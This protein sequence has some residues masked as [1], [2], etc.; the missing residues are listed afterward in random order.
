MTFGSSIGTLRNKTALLATTKHVHLPT[1]QEK[2]V[3]FPV[4]KNPAA[5]DAL[6]GLNE[7]TDYGLKSPLGWWHH[8]F[9][10]KFYPSLRRCVELKDK[11]VNERLDAAWLKFTKGSSKEVKSA[12]DLIVEREI[13][14]AQKEDRASDY[15]SKI[16]QDELTAFLMAGNDTTSATLE[17][18]IKY[19][20]A[21]QEWQT[22]LRSTLREQFD[23]KQ[24]SGL[25]IAKINTPELDA[26]VEE[27]L[28]VGSTAAFLFRRTK[29]DT[30]ILGHHV[31]AKT[32]LIMLVS[33]K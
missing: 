4:A 24:P 28:R 5:Y 33:Q 11:M 14:L 16:I 12:A 7:S 2:P 25:Q 8:T 31:P 21:H 18:A 32:D 22:K 29:E 13:S 19:L 3:E 30:I 1:D 10:L 26:T 6:V 20:T 27:A 17:W 9:A 23:S 15:K